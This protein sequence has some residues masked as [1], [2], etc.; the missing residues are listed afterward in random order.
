[1]FLVLA[2]CQSESTVSDEVNPFDKGLTLETLVFKSFTVAKLPYQ[3]C[4]G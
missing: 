2:L 1:M 3:P 4:G